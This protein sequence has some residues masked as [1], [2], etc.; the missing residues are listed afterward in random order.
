MNSINTIKLL[1]QKHS[2]ANNDWYY[3]FRLLEGSFDPIKSQ[4]NISKFNQRFSKITKIWNSDYNTEWICRIYFAAKMILT[5]TLNLNSFNYSIERNLYSVVP[6]LAYYS[7]LSLLRA[8]VFV[9]PETEWDDG[10]IIEL[11]HAKTI[12]I[13]VAEIKKYNK[14]L[15]INLEMEVNKFKAYRELISYRS[16]SQGFSHI[17]SYDKLIEYATLLAEFSQMYSEI[18]ESSI[19]KNSKNHDFKFNNKYIKKLTKIEIQGE[20]FI[21]KEDSFRLNYLQQKYPL[22]PNI[23]HIMTQGHVEDFFGNWIVNDNLSDDDFNPDQYWEI[24]FDLP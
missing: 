21:D 9:N 12:N 16:P 2:F 15:A 24:I 23:L 3:T 17:G 19:L 6:Y 10:K 11:S 8:I 7:L 20:V 1:S 5:A 14:N 4:K 18:I 22:P 13:A